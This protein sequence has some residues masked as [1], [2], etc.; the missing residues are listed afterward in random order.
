MS[1]LIFFSHATILIISKIL[2]YEENLVLFL[3]KLNY[4][5]KFKDQ[6]P[7]D[8]YLTKIVLVTTKSSTE[9]S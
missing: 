3:Q 5:F 9:I 7:L 6:F 2:T 1:H 4:T 8:S